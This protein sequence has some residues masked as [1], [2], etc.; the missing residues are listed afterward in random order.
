MDVS[1]EKLNLS[2]LLAKIRYIPLRSAGGLRGALYEDTPLARERLT[3]LKARHPMA[4]NCIFVAPKSR[5][6]SLWAEALGPALTRHAREHLLETSPQ[7]SA[8]TTAYRS[9]KMA[10]LALTFVFVSWA[11]IALPSMLIALNVMF[12]LFYAFVGLV[13]LASAFTPLPREVRS[14]SPPPRLSDEDLPIYTVLVPLYDEVEIVPELIAGL[15]GLDYPVDKLDIMILAESDDAATLSALAAQIMPPHISIIKVPP[16]HPRTKPKALNFAL[17]LGRGSI[18]TIYDAEDKP[19]PDQL[20]KAVWAFREADQRPGKPLGCVQAALTI[21]NSERSFFTRHFAFEYMALFDA[22]LPAL[23]QLDLPIPLG[24]TSNHFRRDALVACGGWDPYNVTEDADLGIRLARLGYRTQM[25]ASSTREFAPVR[26]LPWL[27]Q[28]SRWFKGWWQTWLVHMRHP[29][30]L[31]QRLGLGGFLTFQMIMLGV[32]VSVLIHPFFFAFTVAALLG[33]AEPL[34]KADA[35]IIQALASINVANFF[36][37]YLA[38]AA[39][40]LR[41]AHRR[42]VKGVLSTLATI[43]VY[44]LFLSLGG[45]VALWEL[46]WRPHHWHK[47]PHDHANV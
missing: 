33:I 6:Q 19:E 5:I 4:A 10:L 28:R 13:R 26:F 14:S 16:S 43:P 41:G 24:G 1:N 7:F 20:R 37:G 40:G 35:G 46:R 39:L 18:F 45:F 31:A 42:G 15:V 2:G 44:W 12:A 36:L 25:I 23:S 32:L 9:Q 3:R 38:A 22:L 47:T 27:R 30:A 29:L 17:P 11:L 8:K 34:V 21:T